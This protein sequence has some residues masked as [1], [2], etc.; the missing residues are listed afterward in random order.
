MPSRNSASI[1]RTSGWSSKR[2]CVRAMPTSTSVKSAA[3]SRGHTSPA[4]CASGTRSPAAHCQRAR[5]SS[6]SA[7]AAGAVEQHLHVVERVVGIA[8]RVAAQ[9]VVGFVLGGVPAPD[10]DV[11]P[12]GEGDGVVD[13]DQLLVLRGAERHRVVE[14]EAHAA[15]RIPAEGIG[16][17]QLALGC[18]EHGEVP[19]QQRDFE[20]RTLVDQRRE[21]IRQP[22]GIAVLGAAARADQS[23][24][25]MDVPADDEGVALGFE[26]RRAHGAEI[27]RRVEDDGGAMRALHAPDIATGT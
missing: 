4:S 23:G 22:L 20:P 2:G 27:G 6:A 8:A 24:L 14:A 12:A 5:A 7:R 21:K 1:S 19:E 3:T 10:G 9:R 25:A 18:V 16:G 15:R 26:Q 13:D 11:E 17:E